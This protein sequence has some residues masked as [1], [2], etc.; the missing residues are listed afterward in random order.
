M[1][2][3]SL[4]LPIFTAFVNSRISALQSE[5]KISA[6][7]GILLLLM[8]AS[9]L[10]PAKV[11]RSWQDA[12]VITTEILERCFL[13]YPA[14]TI[15]VEDNA[16]VS[17][18][19]ENLVQI[20]WLGGNERFSSNFR[21]AVEKGIAA[22]ETK[23]KKKKTSTRGRSINTEDPDAEARVVSDMSAQRLLTL[24]DLIE[25]AGEEAEP[26]EADVMEE[27]EDEGKDNIRIEVFLIVVTGLMLTGYLGDNEATFMTAVD[28]MEEDDEDEDGDEDEKKYCLCQSKESGDM[29]ACDNHFCPYEWFH[30]K[31]VGL[32]KKPR[33]KWLCP[34]CTASSGKKRK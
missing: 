32:K 12:D 13:P 3:K 16:K 14:N 17:V 2:V 22:R 7:Q 31:C 8:P 15:A 6:L 34:E 20:V 4:P 19:L 21:A 25:A 27:D 23:A 1:T 26:T 9:A 11:D 10:S 29:I 18:L 5:Q 24:L 30:W 28:N 33:G